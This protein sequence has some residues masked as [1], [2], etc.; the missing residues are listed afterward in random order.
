MIRLEAPEESLHAWL[1]AAESRRSRRSFDGE[2]LTPAQLDTLSALSRSF[3]PSPVARAVFIPQAPADIFTGI[4]GSYGRI[5]GA[6]SA[7]AFV[8]T[9]GAPGV[10]AAV[11]FTGEGLVLEANRQGLA[12]CWVAGLF[13][14][15]KVARLIGMG[16]GERVFAISPVGRPLETVPGTERVLYRTRLNVP[17]PRKPAEEIAPGFESWPAWAQAGVR[18]VR[19]APSAMNR[20][21]WRLRYE[22]GRIVVSY[23]GVDAPRIS[24]RLDCGIAML[25]FELG[26]R[27]AGVAG[28]WQLVPEGTDVAR[29]RLT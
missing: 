27:A 26:A 4:V 15:H 8:G 13:K 20:Q 1:E 24:K 29:Y 17:K 3:R 6:P 21:P 2:P 12:T 10:E 23:D 11:G 16:G 25:H 19:R 5:S 22:D 14:P 18:E 28:E 9:V 7:L